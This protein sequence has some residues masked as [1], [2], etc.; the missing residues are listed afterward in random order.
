MQGQ[1]SYCPAL[2]L[3]RLH[4]LVVPVNLGIEAMLPQAAGGHGW[5]TGATDASAEADRPRMACF[6]ATT[7]CMQSSTLGQV[8]VRRALRGLERFWRTC[9]L[10]A[11][12]LVTASSD[13]VSSA[14]TSWSCSPAPRISA[15]G[16]LLQL[17]C[18]RLDMPL[19]SG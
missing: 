2:P 1:H 13:S 12:M 7:A 3:S 11:R 6:K 5:Q 18:V 15:V 9:P 10:A 16:A 14:L 4:M 19:F 8:T 17:G